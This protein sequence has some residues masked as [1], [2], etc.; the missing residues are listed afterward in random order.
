M[1]NLWPWKSRL[2]WNLEMLIFMEGRKQE[3]PEKNPRSKH[4]N[5]QQTQPTCD[6]GSGNRTRDTL[7][8]CERPHH[9]ATPFFLLHCTQLLTQLSLQYFTTSL[10]IINRTYGIT[11][12]I[13]TRS[14]THEQVNIAKSHLFEPDMF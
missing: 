10:N 4:K 3:N 13:N 12:L 7:M 11:Q 14:H 5:Q 1:T 8:G 2:N 9:C 6:A